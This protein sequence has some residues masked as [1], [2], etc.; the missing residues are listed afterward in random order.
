MHTNDKCVAKIL[1]HKGT[2]S[3]LFLMTK[4]SLFINILFWT[5]VQLDLEMKLIKPFNSPQCIFNPR[6]KDQWLNR[7]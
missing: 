2:P 4:A 5:T 6:N 7:I 3:Q 1:F